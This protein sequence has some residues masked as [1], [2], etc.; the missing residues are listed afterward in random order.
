MILAVRMT[1][2]CL[3]GRRP[4]LRAGID[5]RPGNE[6]LPFAQEKGFYRG[7]ALEV[8]P[9]DFNSLTGRA[10]RQAGQITG[11]DRRAHFANAGF[12]QDDE[13]NP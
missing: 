3:P 10:L 9:L 13:L 2:G 8:C 11:K 4:A 7:E 1:T 12:A 6:F 5:A